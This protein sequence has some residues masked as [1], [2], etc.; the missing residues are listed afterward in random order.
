MAHVMSFALAS[1]A[2]LSFAAWAFML[3]FWGQFWR[4][5][6]RLRPVPA[7]A[8]WPEI[9]GVIPARDEADSIARVVGAH[10]GTHYPGAFSLIVVDDASRDGTG[11][12]A[13]AAA[14]NRAHELSVLEGAPLPPGWTGKLWAQAQ[15]IAAA[16][17]A[18]PGARYVLLCDADIAF[19]PDTLQAL[20]AKAEAEGL[21]LVSLMAR[22]D[23][24]GPSASLLIPAFIFFFQK[25]YPF[26]WANDAR[27]GCAAAA[28]GVMLV[29]ADALQDLDLPASIRGAL[30]DDCSLAARIKRSGRRIW[31][32]LAEPGA[33]VSLRDNRALSSIWSMVAR[34]AYAQLN[35]SPALLAGALLGMALLYLAGP[36]AALS[37]ALQGNWAPAWFGGAA[38][39]LMS[40]A[41]LPTTIDYRRPWAAPFLPIAALLY[42]A[43]TFDSALRSWRGAGGAWKGRTYPA[44]PG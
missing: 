1:A 29:R 13:R 31:I 14:H 28:G 7:P 42:G 40:L 17:S 16:R 5:N 44:A 38:W 36:I 26:A 32:G 25:L 4:A 8:L 22:L 12:L 33:A 11:D 15:G 34:T 43:M 27:H 39:L 23:A 6:Q 10:L 18:A 30:I 3:A 2:V 24:R 37:G 9:V 20:V 21:S 19:G 35:H 41:F